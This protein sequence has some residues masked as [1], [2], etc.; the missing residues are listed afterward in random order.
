[1]AIALGN[2]CFLRNE[3]EYVN[4]VSLRWQ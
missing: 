1:M 3:N 2:Q 4:E